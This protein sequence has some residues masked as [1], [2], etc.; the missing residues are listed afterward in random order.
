ML[1]EC[2]HSYVDLTDFQ[3]WLPSY[4][5]A[6]QNFFPPPPNCLVVFVGSFALEWL[7]KLPISQSISLLYTW[8][9]LH[10]D[11]CIVPV[12]EQSYNEPH[13]PQSKGRHRYYMK[14]PIVQ[15]RVSANRY[16]TSSAV[17]GD[18]KMRAAISY[19]KCSQ[20]AGVIHMT[21]SQQLLEQSV[22][23]CS[24]P[25][26]INTSKC[27]HCLHTHASS[28]EQDHTAQ[29]LQLL[30]QSCI[31]IVAHI[32]SDIKICDYCLCSTALCQSYLMSHFIFLL[33]SHSTGRSKRWSIS[34]C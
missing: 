10:P 9:S 30:A 6:Y 27:A 14:S 15:L 22:S 16:Q 1:I 23:L 25:S 24:C 31:I 29:T 32:C 33:Y 11:L 5:L 17:M 19:T 7:W 4:F 3:L 34:K 26:N 8:R 20:L 18:H 13:L 2:L 21:G 28:K 12:H